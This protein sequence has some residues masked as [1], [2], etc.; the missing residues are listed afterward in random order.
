MS[1]LRGVHVLVYWCLFLIVAIVMNPQSK[2]ASSKITI[3]VACYVSGSCQNDKIPKVEICVN[4]QQQKS[5]MIE[6]DCI[7]S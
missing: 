5:I 1:L 3:L 7:L 4:I 2:H 6:A